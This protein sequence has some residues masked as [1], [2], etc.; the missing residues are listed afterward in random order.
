MEFQVFMPPTVHPTTGY[1]HA[2]RMGNL[3]FVA[4]QVARNLQ[5]E[6]IAKGDV[7]AQTEQAY[8]N[9]QAVLEAAGSGLD[10]VGKI[11]VYTTS[12]A[13]REVISDVR[14]QVFEKVGHIPAATFA[15]VASLA[16]PDYLVEI[17]AVAM[18]REGA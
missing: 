15:V 1:A 6:I 7:R 4:G 3:I 9:L 5:G 8:A 10:L 11:T 12:R 16:D 18:V 14:R 17:E 13:Y 2:V